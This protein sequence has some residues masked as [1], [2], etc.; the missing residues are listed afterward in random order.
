MGEASA[1]CHRTYP[2]TPAATTM[3]PSAMPTAARLAMRSPPLHERRGNHREREID[4]GQTPQAAPVVHHLAKACAE[5][6]D[7]DDAVDR[8]IRREYVPRSRHRRWDCFAWPGKARHQKL[9]K[10]GAEKDE[11][12]G[13]RLPEPGARRLSHE[14]GREREQR[15]ER[16]ELHRMAEG[17]KSVEA[18]RQAGEERKRG[19]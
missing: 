2:P 5:L 15:R 6:A 4:D 16:E 19:H 18:G 10:A 17:C 1:R 14:T 9:R 3:R 11:R 12:R 7:T 8:E 13:F